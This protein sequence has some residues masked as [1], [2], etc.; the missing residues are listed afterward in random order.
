MPVTPIAA[1]IKEATKALIEI[2]YAERVI[3]YTVATWREF[4]KF[5]DDNRFITYQSEIKDKFVSRVNAYDPPL[6]HE[7]IL[8]K[9]SCMKKLDAFALKS[10]WEKGVVLQKPLLPTEF[11]EFLD[12]QDE[13][14]VKKAY[15]EHTR[16]VIRELS[17]TFML[18]L[19]NMGITCLSEINKD[20]ISEFLLTFKGH[21]KSTL[22]GELSR[23]RRFLH[24]LYLTERTP[25]DL[26]LYVPKYH[27]GPTDSIV[28]IWRSDE[29]NKVLE[30]VDVSNPRGKRDNA[31]ITIAVQLGMRTA[32]ILNIKLSD[33][34]WDTGSL[35]FSQSKNGN[36]NALPLNEEVGL[37]IIDYL[38]VRPQT[39]S[40]YLFVNLN[41][42]YEQMR[43]FASSFMRYYKRGKYTY[44]Q[45]S[46]P[47][48]A[49]TQGHRSKQIACR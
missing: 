26:S 25:N 30:S 18:F 48:Y 22:R 41:P 2:G 39:D 20:H 15:A 13:L 11:K 49:F 31:I 29:I 10:S 12:V 21:A 1:L 44:R 16:K 45:Q 5:C 17:Y 40:P 28:K 23:L 42:P 8:R 19:L 3:E 9:A 34:D 33:F 27:F 43:R 4:E 14:L 7:T 36:P 24:H 32:D 46:P 37:A 38:R 47:R 6:K 35:Y